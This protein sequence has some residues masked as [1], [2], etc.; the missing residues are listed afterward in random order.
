MEEKRWNE[1]IE[2]RKAYMKNTVIPVID[3]LK[4]QERDLTYERAEKILLDAIDFLHKTSK[5]QKL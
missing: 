5:R 4:E 3:F 1:F 2:A